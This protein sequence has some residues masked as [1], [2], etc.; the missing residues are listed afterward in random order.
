MVYHY[1]NFHIPSSNSLLVTALELRAKH[2]F[3]A[4]T[5][6]MFYILKNP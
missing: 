6:L 1:I 3:H 5:I 4:V 2:K